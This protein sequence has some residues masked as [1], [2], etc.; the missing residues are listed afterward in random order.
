MAEDPN[1]HCMQ[2]PSARAPSVHLVRLHATPCAAWR[3]QGYPGIASTRVQTIRGGQCLCQLHLSS[4]LLPAVTWTADRLHQLEAPGAATNSPQ[5][6][7]LPKAVAACL[8]SS[9]SCCAPAC[10]GQAEASASILAAVHRE[11]L[12]SMTCFYCLKHSSH[13]DKVPC[14]L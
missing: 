7:A 3:E 8:H 4:A 12:G 13:H 1:T 6:G 11:V 2:S 10:Q 14:C 5:V 9:C